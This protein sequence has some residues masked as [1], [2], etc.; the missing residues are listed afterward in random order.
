M[1]LKKF[2]GTT[3]DPVAIDTA[4]G[5]IVLH[6]AGN[7]DYEPGSGYENAPLLIDTGGD[8]TYNVPTGATTMTDGSGRFSVEVAIPSNASVGAQKVVALGTVSKLRVA[9]VFLVT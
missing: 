6:G 8:D 3:F 5:K 2:A 4:I 7:D 9:Q 1:S